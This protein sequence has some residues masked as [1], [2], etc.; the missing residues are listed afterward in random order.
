MILLIDNYDSFTYNLYQQVS[1][2]GCEV[3]VVKNDEVSIADIRKMAP[4]K[5]II[6]PGPG[7]PKDGGISMTVIREFYRDVPILGVCLGL[8]AIG[9]VFGVRVVPAR[10]VMHG[11]TSEIYHNGV[12]LFKGV[13][14]PFK[15]ARYHSLILEKVPEDFELSA[16]TKDGEIMGIQHKVLPLCGV[17]FHPESFM[18]EEGERVMRNFIYDVSL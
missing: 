6:S 2:F 7:R 11:K 9:E 13:S 16:W 14:R 4:S 12:G 3:R 17:Q 1:S 8:E 18:T 10:I 5:I 15:A